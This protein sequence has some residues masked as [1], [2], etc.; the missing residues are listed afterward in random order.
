MWTRLFWVSVP[1]I[2]HGARAR[3]QDRDLVLG[4]WIEHGDKCA[5]DSSECPRPLQTPAPSSYFTHK[6]LL[7]SFKMAEG[8][9]WAPKS[10]QGT[11]SYR[12]PGTVP[13]NSARASS[14]NDAFKIDFTGLHIYFPACPPFLFYRGLING[15]LAVKIIYNSP[16]SLYSHYPEIFSKW[17]P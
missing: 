16:E 3:V 8:Q 7:F 11:V 12:C 15:L 14:V 9:R 10:E 1:I 17:E 6:S 5:H 2:G 4:H 13:E